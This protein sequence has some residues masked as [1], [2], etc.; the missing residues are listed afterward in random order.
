MPCWTPH[1]LLDPP[2][3]VGPPMVHETPHGRG[4]FCGPR[5]G[6]RGFPIVFAKFWWLRSAEGHR[7]GQTP[8]LLSD[9]FVHNEL[10]RRC[11]LRWQSESLAP[12]VRPASKPLTRCRIKRRFSQTSHNLL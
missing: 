10:M 7:P 5:G 1:A 2:C 4:I 11:L 3:L 9:T 12:G 6:E 8:L